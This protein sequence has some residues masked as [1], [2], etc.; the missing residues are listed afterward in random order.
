[1]AGKT[2]V[3]PQSEKPWG[4]QNPGKIRCPFVWSDGHRCDGHVTEAHELAPTAVWQPHEGKWIYVGTGSNR[5]DQSTK[6]HLICSKHGAHEGASGF[7]QNGVLTDLNGLPED[8]AR[9]IEWARAKR[10]PGG[11]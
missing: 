8:L 10:L 11:R 6:F 7:R 1:M 9:E 2:N 4:A 3:A 5:R